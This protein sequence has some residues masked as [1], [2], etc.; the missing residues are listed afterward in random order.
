MD[1]AIRAQHHVVVFEFCREF[2]SYAFYLHALS[3]Y[4]NRMDIFEEV[5]RWNELLFLC[6]WSEFEPPRILRLSLNNRMQNDQEK[7]VPNSPHWDP[8]PPPIP[9][10]VPKKKKKPHRP[11]RSR[12]WSSGQWSDYLVDQIIF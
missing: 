6:K 4:K 9:F 11:T 10:Y 8:P 1:V 2:C 5:A 7:I 12:I 3:I